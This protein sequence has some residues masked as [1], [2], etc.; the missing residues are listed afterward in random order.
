MSRPSLP[1]LSQHLPPVS[2]IT[3]IIHRILARLPDADLE[4]V[5]LSVLVGLLSVFF[6]CR[7]AAARSIA[8]GMLSF[9]GSRRGVDKLEVGVKSGKGVAASLK[10][11]ILRALGLERVEFSGEMPVEYVK[12][13]PYFERAA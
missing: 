10:V 8:T 13:T 7:C 11:D 9:I 6:I 12:Y 3:S 1:L 5:D 4:L 2:H